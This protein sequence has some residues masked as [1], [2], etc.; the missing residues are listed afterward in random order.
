VVAWRAYEVLCLVL[1]VL[2]VVLGAYRET[3]IAMGWL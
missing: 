1:G 3:A 2:L